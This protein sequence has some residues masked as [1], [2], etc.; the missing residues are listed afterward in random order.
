MKRALQRVQK[1]HYFIKKYSPVYTW[2]DIDNTG[3][4]AKFSMILDSFVLNLILGKY[5]SKTLYNY[6]CIYF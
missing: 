1:L 5:V 4:Y 3:I 2:H 6:I